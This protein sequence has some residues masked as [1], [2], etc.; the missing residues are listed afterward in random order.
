MTFAKPMPK[1]LKRNHRLPNINDL[2]RIITY[3]QEIKT[4]AH[5]RLIRD[6]TGVESK[7]IKNALLWLVTHGILSKGKNKALTIYYIN[8]KINEFK[9]EN[10]NPKGL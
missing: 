5:V 8:P 1:G 2:T 6:E 9:L 4:Q 3:L 10:T 7:R